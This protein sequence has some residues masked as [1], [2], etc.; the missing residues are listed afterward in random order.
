MSHLLNPLRYS[1][2]FLF[3]VNRLRAVGGGLVLRYCEGQF[4]VTRREWVMIALLSDAGSVTPTELAH[5]SDM[6]R[7]AT[8]K[9]ISSLLEKGL[10][11]RANAAG[12]RRFIKLVLSQSGTQL[13]DRMLPIVHDINRH[14]M[15]S[16]SDVEIVLLDD[17]MKRMQLDAEQLRDDSVSLPRVSRGKGG[18]RHKGRGHSG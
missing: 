3:R 1:D 8:S 9:A 5:L 11:K 17:M 4:G 10:I 14:I 6:T 13:Y 12:D 2:F 15:K 18:T 16:L 7:S